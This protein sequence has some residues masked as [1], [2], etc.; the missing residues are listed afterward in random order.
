[1]AHVPTDSG[2]ASQRLFQPFPS[3]SNEL[4]YM[5]ASTASSLPPRAVTL[6]NSDSEGNGNEGIGG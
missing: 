1:M 3:D 2:G 5:R 4:N 6:W